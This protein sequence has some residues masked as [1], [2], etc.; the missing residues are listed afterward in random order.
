MKKKRILLGIA[1]ASASIFALASCG[2]NDNNTPNDD[3]TK[4]TSGEGQNQGGNESQ[5]GNE[6]Q[7]GNNNQG[8]NG[9]QQGG[10]EQTVTKYSIT[11][12]VNGH[13]TAPA[14]KTDVTAITTAD[15]AAIS[16]SGYKFDGWYTDAALTT[17]A[18]A[19]DINANTTLYAKWIAVSY[20]AVKAK[21]NV[22]LD[23][24]FTSTTSVYDYSYF[25]SVYESRVFFS[26]VVHTDKPDS[27]KSNYTYSIENGKFN[28]VDGDT[29]SNTKGSSKGIV[30]F[31]YTADTKILEGYVDVTI[32]VKNNN[33]T[34]FQLY[35]VDTAKNN[36]EIFGL[37]IVEEG[38]GSDK[39]LYVKYR[40]DGTVSSEGIINPFVITDN[41]TFG[42]HMVID[43]STGKITIDFV[44]DDGEIVPF[45][46][47]VTIPG[48]VLSSRY[49]FTST[50]GGNKVLSFTNVLLRGEGT[51]DDVDQYKAKVLA[52]YNPLLAEMST[53][54]VTNATQFAAAKD[55]IIAAVENATTKDAINALLDSN[56]QTA[57]P[58]MVALMSVESE[59]DIAFN[60]IETNYPKSN[61]TINGTEYYNAL[62]AMYNASTIEELNTAKA[63]FANIENDAVAKTAYIA[64][65]VTAFKN[66]YPETNYTC[67]YTN[68]NNKTSYDDLVASITGNNKTEIDSSYEN[69]RIN[70]PGIPIDAALLDAAQTAYKSSASSYRTDTTGK[71]LDSTEETA[72]ANYYQGL[73]FLAKVTNVQ[74]SI[75]MAQTIDAVL[76]AYNAFTASVDVDINSIVMTINQLKENRIAQLQTDLAGFKE[77]KSQGVQEALDAAAQLATKTDGT[78]NSATTKDDVKAAYTNAYNALDLIVYKDAQLT[79]LNTWIADNY[80]PGAEKEIKTTNAAIQAEFSTITNNVWTNVNN[81][82]TKGE[83]GELN[84]TDGIIPTVQTAIENK[85]QELLTHEFTVTYSGTYEAMT[86][87]SV[88]YGYAVV[89]PGNPTEADDKIFAGWFADSECTTP[90]DFT[91]LRYDDVTLYAKYDDAVIIS[92]H[93]NKV[94]ATPVNGIKIASGTSL[95]ATDLAIT[96]DGYEFIGWYQNADFSG[97]AVTTSTVFNSNTTIYAKWADIID[98]S[99]A[100][101]NETWDLNALS[102]TLGSGKTVAAGTYSNVFTLS[103]NSNVKTKSENSGVGVSFKAATIT[104]TTTSPNATLTLVSYSAQSKRLIALDQDI[105]TQAEQSS[106]WTDTDTVKK[107]SSTTTFTIATPG[108]HYITF[109]NTEHKLLSISLSC[110]AVEDITVFSSMTATVTETDGLI[111]VSDVKLIPSTATSE[112]DYM[113]ISTG[114]TIEVKNSSNVVVDYSNPLSAGTYNVYVKYGSYTV[115]TKSVP[116]VEKHTVTINGTEYKIADGDT[117][118]DKLPASDTKADDTSNSYII[119]YEFTGWE[120]AD[121]NPVTSSTVVTSDMV[122]TPVF[123]EKYYVATESAF[124]DALALGE[125]YL[126]ANIEITSDVTIA[127][128]LTINCGDYVI[129]D[130]GTAKIILNNGVTLVCDKDIEISLKPMSDS[131]FIKKTGTGPYTYV[132]DSN[133]M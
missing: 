42:I 108:V 124:A 75:D 112:S 132:L 29:D 85:Y 91:T 62:Y 47:D 54:Y 15:L 58:E 13:G 50:D 31:G 92:L 93:S 9:G 57:A 113:A 39:K 123:E 59:W 34:F 5:G 97:D 105:K 38:S 71:D 110:A 98:N 77:G 17:A 20:D 122:I 106:N 72:V 67:E 115:Y 51:I 45:I 103:D 65:K 121:H 11:Y 55:A 21:G 52:Y 16:A 129:S 53:R 73:E 111:S 125:I 18:V 46:K 114:Y 14:N 35:G 95:S 25:N 117:L 84:G 74:E 131:Y 96:Q 70:A 32:P 40:V 69:A 27:P 33:W 116:I 24:Q 101:V 56:P 99:V 4:D 118:G 76:S 60:Y 36:N 83:I 22:V 78:I 6:N 12:D 37:R 44:K 43:Q 2:G 64:S 100:A 82:G 94:A 7:G 63:A 68:Y 127:N 86:A 133:I 104:F 49:L 81:A 10:G 30:N 3:E 41:I 61:Y 87:G 102:T 130:N 26:G 88:V 107:L 48:Y 126:E 8:G 119:K 128:D 66:L 79:A 80:G 90:F 120:D 23:E 109:D 89:N 19:G 1:L 28:L